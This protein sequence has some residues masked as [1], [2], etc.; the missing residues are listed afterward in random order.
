MKEC[1]RSDGG[2]EGDGSIMVTGWIQNSY[3]LGPS[4]STQKN[5]F[6][7]KLDTELNIVYAKSFGKPSINIQCLS[8]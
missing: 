7:L 8:I 3:T 1:K 6:V 5:C 4:T 2:D